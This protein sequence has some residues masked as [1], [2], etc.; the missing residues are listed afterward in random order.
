[1]FLGL[2]CS[3]VL[4]ISS[5]RKFPDMESLKGSQQRRKLTEQTAQSSCCIACS[6]ELQVPGTQAQRRESHL[7]L[8]FI[9]IIILLG[10]DLAKKFCRDESISNSVTEL[11]GPEAL[12][13][14]SA[15]QCTDNSLN[16]EGSLKFPGASTA[17]SPLAWGPRVLAKP[18]VSVCGAATESVSPSGDTHPVTTVTNFLMGL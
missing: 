9:L 18:C 12:F 10:P 15:P 17:L 13:F 11:Q 1:M 8:W 4:K 6:L 5:L 2:L 7:C 14:P 3:V 16:L